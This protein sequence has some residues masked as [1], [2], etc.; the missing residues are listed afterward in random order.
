[1]FRWAIV[2]T[3]PMLLARLGHMPMP[4]FCEPLM[5]LFRKAE[6]SWVSIG[7]N[8]WGRSGAQIVHAA[9]K[10]QFHPGTLGAGVLEPLLGCCQVP[11]WNLRTLSACCPETLEPWNPKGAVGRCDLN[12]SLGFW[13]LCRCSVFL[14]C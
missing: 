11:R 13:G 4:G 6:C 1:M 14:R 12:A 10:P 3:F 9:P 7:F 2:G 5:V 8:L